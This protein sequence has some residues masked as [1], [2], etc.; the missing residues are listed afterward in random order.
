METE[1]P[2]GTV[3]PVVDSVSPG[4]GAEAAGLLPGDV[5]LAA[6]GVPVYANEDLLAARRTHIVGENIILT[7][8]RGDHTFEADVYL[9]PMED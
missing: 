3:H 4:Y 2:D 9:Y 1:Q 6:D 8:R 7:V 5:I